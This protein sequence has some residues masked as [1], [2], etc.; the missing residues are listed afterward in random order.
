MSEHD[1]QAIAKLIAAVEEIRSRRT[2]TPE[3]LRA[4]E[5]VINFVRGARAVRWLFGSGFQILLF[6]GAGVAAVAAAKAG[7]LEWL[8]IQR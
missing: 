4:L 7:L 3:E 5:D 1:P 2:W 8:G 6:I